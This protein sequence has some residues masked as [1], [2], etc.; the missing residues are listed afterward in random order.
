MPFSW[1]ARNRTPAVISA[2]P[3][4]YPLRGSGDRHCWN[5]FLA[6]VQTGGPGLSLARRPFGLQVTSILAP[7]TRSNSVLV[8]SYSHGWGMAHHSCEAAYQSGQLIQ[9]PDHAVDR[10]RRR[11]IVVPLPDG[12]HA[13]G[14]GPSNVGH[15]VVAD[16]DRLFRRDAEVAHGPAKYLRVRLGHTFFPRNQDRPEIT[17]R[18][19]DRRSSAAETWLDRWSRVP[20]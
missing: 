3:M 18:C 10:I 1:S 8:F 2:R 7:S 6:C 14:P 16:H 13:E 5:S 4:G 17:G 12:L 20:T 15:R 11:P 19:P 9:V